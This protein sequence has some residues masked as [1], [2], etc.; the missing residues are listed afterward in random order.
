MRKKGSSRI[1][2][3]GAFEYP[4]Q[5]RPGADQR[6]AKKLSGSVDRCLAHGGPVRRKVNRLVRMSTERFRATVIT[7]AVCRNNT[8]LPEITEQDVHAELLELLERERIRAIIMY[9]Q[10]AKE[11]L[12]AADPEDEALDM[13]DTIDLEHSVFP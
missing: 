5:L 6:K 1:V 3:P 8:C 7:D 11:R 2:C 4:L 9:Q 10:E 12:A 13:W